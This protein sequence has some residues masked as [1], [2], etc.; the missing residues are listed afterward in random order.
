MLFH[1]G[2]GKR[3]MAGS[4]RRVRREDRRGAYL[5]DRILVFHPGKHEL[6]DALEHHEG[7][8]AFVGVERRGLNAEGP[9]DTH[10]ANTED[11]LLADAMFLV[12]TVE[13]RC[14]FTF[15]RG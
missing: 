4:N 7:S 2:K 3:V 5:L 15:R 1:H 6:T 9:E 12:A 8:V 11:D 14:Q 13:A 10:A